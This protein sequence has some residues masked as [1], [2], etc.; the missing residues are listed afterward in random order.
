[1][2]PWLSKSLFVPTFAWNF[3]L[4]RVLKLRHWWDPIDDAVILGAMPLSSDVQPLFDLGVR[5]VINT[6]KEYSG[7]ISEYR[8]LHITQL[9][10]PTVD[11]NPPSLDDVRRGVE[12]IE[13]TIHDGGKVYVHC[14]AGRARSATIVICWLV[15]CRTM[16]LDQA[17]QHLLECRPHVN[18]LL[19]ERAVVK[20]FCEG[21][22]VRQAATL[23]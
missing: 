11:F 2:H 8:R 6:C 23:I 13:K 4:G 3:T 16:T 19:K 5:G 17:Q 7:P 1:M 9:W 22:K 12:F 15:A 18:R 10:L 20:E 14:K 21:W